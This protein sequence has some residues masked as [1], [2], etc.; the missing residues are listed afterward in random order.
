MDGVWVSK[1]HLHPKSGWNVV[2]G[3][4]FVS[5][6]QTWQWN[7]RKSSV[8][9]IMFWLCFFSA[10]AKQA[11]KSR[12]QKTFCSNKQ[13]NNVILVIESWYEWSQIPLFYTSIPNRVSLTFSCIHTR[14]AWP[15]QNLAGNP[16]W[17]SNRTCIE[18]A[19]KVVC[20]QIL[21]IE[22]LNSNFDL[23]INWVGYKGTIITPPGKCTV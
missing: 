7:K 6:S 22:F 13:I 2:S 11:N 16:V 3:C 21:C 18:L 12:D 5:P 9:E 19:N 10:A 23:L 20:W 1:T 15:K 8:T 17:L 4:D 14:T